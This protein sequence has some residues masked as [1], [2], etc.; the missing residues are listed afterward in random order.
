MTGREEAAAEYHAF[1]ENQRDSH[2]LDAAEINSLYQEHMDG[3]RDTYLDELE[4]NEWISSFFYIYPWSSGS[5]SGLDHVS[6][7]EQLQLFM[8]ICAA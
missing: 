6:T 1:L 2:L 7:T 8:I 3:A 4:V 5:L